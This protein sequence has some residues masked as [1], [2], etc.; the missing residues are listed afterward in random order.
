VQ[1]DL[2]K[3]VGENESVRIRVEETYTDPVGYTVKNGEIEWTRTLGRPLNYVSLPDGWTLT[4]VNT[5]AIVTLDPQGRTM[6]R[7]ANIRNDQLS[8][9]IRARKR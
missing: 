8:V 7:F 4:S 2:P 1:G 3:A 5:P 6:L 9:T